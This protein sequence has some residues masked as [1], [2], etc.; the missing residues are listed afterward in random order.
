MTSLN[1]SR[2]DVALNKSDLHP[3]LYSFAT[4]RDLMFGHSDVPLFVSAQ[5]SSPQDWIQP[6]SFGIVPALSLSDSAPAQSVHVHSSDCA[7]SVSGE[8][9][10]RVKS[11]DLTCVPLAM[12]IMA[13]VCTSPTCF[14]RPSQI[15]KSRS[16]RRLD[17]STRLAICGLF[18]R[19]L[20]RSQSRLSLPSPSKWKTSCLHSKRIMHGRE[21]CDASPLRSC[22]NFSPDLLMVQRPYRPVCTSHIQ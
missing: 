5:P 17:P 19:K 4:L 15:S 3:V 1:P 12:H 22:K 13:D 6:S 10:R 8:E 2:G 7:S 16:S 14:Q 21:S 9:G 18:V 20:T 11:N